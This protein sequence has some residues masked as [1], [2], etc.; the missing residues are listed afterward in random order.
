MKIQESILKRLT[1]K[2]PVSRFTLRA[3]LNAKGFIISDRGMR[4]IINRLR[5][6]GGHLIVS[7]LKGYKLATTRKEFEEHIKFK[8]SYALAILRECKLMKRNFQR[9]IKPQLY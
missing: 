9:S 2:T 3:Y 7:T 6:K 5:D 8:K 1:S 4:L